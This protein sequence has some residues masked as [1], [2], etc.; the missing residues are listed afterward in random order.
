MLLFLLCVRTSPSRAAF[1]A[2][3]TALIAHLPSQLWVV[4]INPA[5]GIA[6][7]LITTLSFAVPAYLISALCATPLR[8]ARLAWLAPA[9]FVTL[10]TAR[11]HILPPFLGLHALGSTVLKGNHSIAFLI[12]IR[13]IGVHGVTAVLCLGG[14]LG[15]FL[16]LRSRS[17][18][19]KAGAV[20]VPIGVC[21]ALSI[22][23][24][25][26]SG[27]DEELI[28]VGVQTESTD[29]AVISQ[30]IGFAKDLPRTPEVIVWPERSGLRDPTTD[31][32]MLHEIEQVLAEKGW[33]IVVGFEDNRSNGE[34]HNA[35]ALWVPEGHEVWRVSQTRPDWFSGL[36]PG[37]DL[38]VF[39]IDGERVGFV[40]GTDLDHDSVFRRLVH[41][42]AAVVLVLSDDAGW[43][44]IGAELHLT[45]MV[46][47]AVE[48]GRDIGRVTQMGPSTIARSQGIAFTIMDRGAEGF[49][50]SN[51]NYYHDTTLFVRAG[52]LFPYAVGVLL[53][54]FL[55]TRLI[56]IRR[57][58][59]A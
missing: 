8:L 34:R 37:H 25:D 38:A 46:I 42:G 10:E 36:E 13:N 7:P 50:S 12:L 31:P 17:V 21:A 58:R 47:R 30:F 4:E 18:L 45:T 23:I 20:F 52:W 59:S 5:I 16:W 6:V 41:S 53:L 40:I 24:W 55:L 49:V 9:L 33:P 22:S 44:D 27:M 32:A 54:L 29:F 57:A 56:L 1:W 19:E 39:E 14:A 51:L 43:S 28:F 35:A 2:S 26:S 15:T 11:S 48:A 3:V